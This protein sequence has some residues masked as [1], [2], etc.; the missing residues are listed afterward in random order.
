MSKRNSMDRKALDAVLNQY[1]GAA[2]AN[3]DGLAF[4]DVPPSDTAERAQ[5]VLS[6]EPVHE[7]HDPNPGLGVCKGT[8]L[9]DK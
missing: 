3:D 2:E 4:A 9:Q 1:K 8:D 5:E 6:Y 7:Q